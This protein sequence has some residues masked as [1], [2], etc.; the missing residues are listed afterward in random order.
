[1]TTIRSLLRG[2]PVV[3]SAWAAMAGAAGAAKGVA[4][5]TVYVGTY[6]QGESKGIYR[7]HFNPK[8]GALG[9]LSLVAE[10]PNPSWLVLHPNGR[11]LYAANESGDVAKDALSAFAVQPDGRLKLLNAKPSRG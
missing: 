2:I 10:T 6:T 4:D 8:T 5:V 7:L 11:F 1:M 3:L 9:D